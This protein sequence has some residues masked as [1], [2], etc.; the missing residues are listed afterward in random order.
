M[1]MSPAQRKLLRP[2]HLRSLDGLDA[3][4]LASAGVEAQRV[5]SV[6][7]TKWTLC[8]KVHVIPS[9]KIEYKASI[10]LWPNVRRKR[11]T[12]RRQ[13]GWLP[14]LVKARWYQACERQLRRHGYRGR[15][16]WSPWGRFGDFWKTLEDFSSLAREARKLEQLRKDPGFPAGPSHSLLQR[17]GARVARPD[18]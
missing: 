3:W 13:P 16:Q 9:R 10:T 5:V 6:G 7:R 15:W 1:A 12:S 11:F 18:R 4:W 17:T 2:S 8:Y 14:D